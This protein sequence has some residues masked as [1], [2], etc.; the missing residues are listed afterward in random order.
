MVAN[1]RGQYEHGREVL[2]AAISRGAAVVNDERGLLDRIGENGV[3]ASAIGLIH[4]VPQLASTHRV[5]N[6]DVLGE[7]P[8]PPLEPQRGPSGE[9]MVPLGREAN[10][11]YAPNREVVDVE[12]RLTSTADALGTGPSPRIAKWI[13]DGGL[14]EGIRA[15]GESHGDHEDR[16]DNER[17]KTILPHGV[18]PFFFF[19]CRALQALLTPLYHTG[20]NYASI[21]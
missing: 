14:R 15:V 6:R 18:L 16:H 7:P 4:L 1:D 10:A 20:K 9:Q 21:P 2:N 17:V 12:I 13:D 8:G 19:Q 11:V 5:H 3:H